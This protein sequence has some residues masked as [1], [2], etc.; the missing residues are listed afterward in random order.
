MLVSAGRPGGRQREPHLRAGARMRLRAPRGVA[1]WAHGHQPG[2]AAAGEGDSRPLPAPLQPRKISPWGAFHPSP[3]AHSISQPTCND[4][5]ETL[6][7]T[8]SNIHQTFYPSKRFIADRCHSV[9]AL[10]PGGIYMDMH[11]SID[12]DSEQLETA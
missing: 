5:N 7:R 9:A 4:G 3:G 10:S 6:G 2:A 12:C 1:A 8:H 11:R